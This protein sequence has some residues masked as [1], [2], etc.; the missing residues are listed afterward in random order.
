MSASCV[1][2]ALKDSC[3][4]L[5]LLGGMRAALP[6]SWK[7]SPVRNVLMNSCIPKFILSVSEVAKKGVSARQR[8][9]CLLVTL[10]KPLQE[11][12]KARCQDLEDLGKSC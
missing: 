7:T 3:C 11:C 12:F 10:P 4:H 6:A 1:Y 9:H 8:S 5:G 2:T